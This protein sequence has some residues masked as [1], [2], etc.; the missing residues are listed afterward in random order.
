MKGRLAGKEVE[1]GGIVGLND[2]EEDLFQGDQEKLRANDY[3]G[4]IA[5]YVCAY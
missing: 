4:R 2:K 3:V 5:P 1:E